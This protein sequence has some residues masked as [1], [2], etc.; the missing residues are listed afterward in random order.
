MKHYFNR[1]FSSM[2]VHAKVKKF[3]TQITA[4]A[5]IFWSL[6]LNA[7]IALPANAAITP[8]TVTASATSAQTIVPSSAVTPLLNIDAVASEG[9]TFA[10]VKVAITPSAGFAISDLAALDG[11][12]GTT[13]L[14]LYRDNGTTEGSFD[15]GDTAVTLG[16]PVSITSTGSASRISKITPPSGPRVPTD[17]DVLATGDLLFANISGGGAPTTGY[18]WHIVTTG[19][20]INSAN[21]RLDGAG[22]QPAY[23]V[24]STRVSP[25]APAAYSTFVVNGTNAVVETGNYDLPAAGD[26]VFYQSSTNAGSWGLVTNETL[27]SGIFAISGSVLG[28]DTWRISKVT[29][30]TGVYAIPPGPGDAFTPTGAYTLPVLGDI[31]LYRTGSSAG[32]GMVTNTTLTSNTFAIDNMALVPGLSYSI[33]KLTAYNQATALTSSL[34]TGGQAIQYGDL[35]FGIP[36]ANPIMGV[37]MA[38][39]GSNSFGWHMATGDTTISAADLRLND[40]TVAP[41]FGFTALLYTG[42]AVTVPSDN[43]GATAGADFYIAAK[44]SAGAVNGHAFTASVAPGSIT[45]SANSPTA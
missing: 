15:S 20:A 18:N 16:G 19:A 3:I 36:T 11:A 31:V 7:F 14:S 22:A 45:F 28:N 26:I 32:W 38:S 6:G 44:T 9:E 43:T 12:A 1:S 37:P 4:V 24:G 23:E 10:A 25:F 21:L 41:S 33:S 29:G 39:P 30:Q 17:T 8:L 2:N 27:T 34:P 35:V 5:V 40:Y 42:E 13:G